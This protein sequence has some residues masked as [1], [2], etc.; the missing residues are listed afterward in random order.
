MLLFVVLLSGCYED[1]GNYDYTLN[2]HYPCWYGNKQGEPIDEKASLVWLANQQGYT[3]EQLEQTLD[4]GDMANPKGF[5]QSVRV[6]CANMSSHMQTLTFLVS[7]TLEQLLEL[8]EMLAEREKVGHEYDARKRPDCGTI[9]LGKETECGLY[10][11]W[12][13]GGSVLEIQLEKD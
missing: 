8:N 1:K 9:T 2:A 6:E 12:N 11:P 5:L 3:K 10:D 13:G 7:M 4:Q